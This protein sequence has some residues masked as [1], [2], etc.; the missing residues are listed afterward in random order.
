MPALLKG[1]IDRIFVMGG[2]FGGDHGHFGEA[3]PAG[4]QAV[5]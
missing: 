3:A 2:V 4:E 1:W 5:C